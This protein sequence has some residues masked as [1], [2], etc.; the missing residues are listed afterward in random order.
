MVA[1]GG[2]KV[3]DR[4]ANTELGLCAGTVLEMAYIY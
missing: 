4:G 3:W 2:D 1:A